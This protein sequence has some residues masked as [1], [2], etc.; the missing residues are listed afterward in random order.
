LLDNF[1]YFGYIQKQLNNKNRVERKLNLYRK[2][3]SIENLLTETRCDALEN[4]LNTEQK[5]LED[6]I[7]SFA[8][9]EDVPPKFF[10]LP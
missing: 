8:T 3:E 7:E 10:F 4:R 6:C 9:D 1:F 5:A 2:G